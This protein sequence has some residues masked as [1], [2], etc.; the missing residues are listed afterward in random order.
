MVRA[1]NNFQRQVRIPHLGRSKEKQKAVFTPPQTTSSP[2][3]MPGLGF[4]FQRSI[5]DSKGRFM[6]GEQTIT[7]YEKVLESVK[8]RYRKLQRFSR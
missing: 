3:N 6:S 8:A 4:D 7:W 2:S 5:L 1:T